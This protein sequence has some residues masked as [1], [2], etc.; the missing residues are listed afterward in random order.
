MNYMRGDL[1]GRKFL[2]LRNN[3]VPRRCTYYKIWKMYF[4]K[5]YFSSLL[6]KVISMF[7]Q[8]TD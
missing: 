8:S 7:S 5:T 3:E 6:R 1:L 2:L 4:I